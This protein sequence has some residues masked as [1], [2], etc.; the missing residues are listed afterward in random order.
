MTLSPKEIG[1]KLAA[2]GR[3][4]SRPL[5]IYGSESVPDS[6]K[7]MTS[8]DRCIA[9]AIFAASV[10]DDLPPL[11]FGKGALAGC[12]P[13]GVGWTG[14]GRLAPMLEYFVSYGTPEF[15][16]GEGEFLKATP[17]IVRASKEA[18]GTITPP[19]TYTVVQACE[20]LD[21][22]PGIRAVVCFGNSEQIRNLS[23]LIHFR[24]AD[25]FNPVR[26]AWGPTCA[27]WMSYPAGM[28][29]KA[30]AD[31]AYLGPMDPTGNRWFPED[32]LGIGIPIKLAIAMCEDLDGSF[33]VKKPE[34][35]YPVVRED[36]CSKNRT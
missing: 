36:I 6:G 11:Y 22:D 33:I 2:A 18:V 26:A 9:K 35:A 10:S 24:S 13:G 7:L 32:Y 25:P 23:S 1:E 5:C 12:C 3:L 14:Y 8:V 21:H 16:N 17:E 34:V 28:A 29:E 19:G 15:R 4:K 31:A 27:S 20:N 30:P